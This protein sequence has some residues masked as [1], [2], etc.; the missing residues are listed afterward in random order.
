MTIFKIVYWL[1]IIIE[2]AIRAPLQKTWKA[3]AKTDQRVSSTEKVLLG[4]LSM[5]MFFIPLIYSLTNWLDFADYTL[6]LWMGWSGVLLLAGAL[7]IFAR[8]HKDLKTNW[9][10]TLEIRQDHTLITNGIYRLIRHPMYASQWLWVIAQILLLQNWLAGPLDLLF[11][12]FFYVLRVRAEE[13]MMLDTFGDQYRAYMKK[14][15]G[16]IP[17]LFG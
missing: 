12:T 15:G 11:F 6:P 4:L 14:T 9:S 10:P 1:G 5:V 13:K 3:A 2:M 7:F 17:R 16:V 8:A